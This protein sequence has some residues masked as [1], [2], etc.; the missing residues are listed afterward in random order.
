MT[1]LM[2]FF[3]LTPLQILLGFLVVV[4]ISVFIVA[5]WRNIHSDDK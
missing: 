4:G 2:R 3:P 1:F 5:C